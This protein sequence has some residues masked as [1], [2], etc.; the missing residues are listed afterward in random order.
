MPLA[1]LH[2]REPC[3]PRPGADES[4]NG[5]EA[6]FGDLLNH[7]LLI[8]NNHFASDPMSHTNLSAASI[9]PIIN[10]ALKAYEKRTKID[11]LT[12]PLALELQACNSSVTILAVLHQKIQGL[13][14]SRSSSDRRTKW[15]DPTVEV[16]Y[17]LSTALEGRAS[18]VSL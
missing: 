8:T 4:R 2:D 17:T 14:Q 16:M 6:G 10:N 5:H 3:I 9:Q 7:H 15:L 18:L 1:V 12:H 13:E 11:L